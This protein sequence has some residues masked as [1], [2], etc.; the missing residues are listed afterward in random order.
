MLKHAVP[1]TFA[2]LLVGTVAMGAA[3]S[4]DRANEIPKASRDLRN[5]IACAMITDR[6]AFI[7][8]A[9]KLTIRNASGR[10]FVLPEDTRLE[11]RPT[12][13]G[14]MTATSAKLPNGTVIRIRP[15]AITFSMVADTP[16]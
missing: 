2:T 12:S 16:K 10:V 3:T 6:H 11:G 14:H 15:V 1:L 7:V 4:G 5:G 8:L 9:G 13:E